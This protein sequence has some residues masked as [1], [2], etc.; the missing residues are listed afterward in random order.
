MEVGN[1][2]QEKKVCII[3]PVYN[4][5]K[6][7]GYCLNSVLSQT[8]GNWTAILVD[9]GSTDSSAG[10]CRRYEK[11]DDRFHYVRKANGGVSSARNRG[12]E[13]A[14]GDYLAFL[15]SDD[16][17]AQDMLEKLVAAA[18]DYDSNLVV[19]NAMILDFNDPAGDRVVL[20]TY[21]P[22][23]GPRVLSRDVFRETQM[24]TIWQTCM[25]EGPL[26]KLYDL[27]L[28][29]QLGVTF[30][31]E[32][33][34]GEDFVTNLQYYSACGTVVFLEDCGYYYHQSAGSGSLSEKYRPDLFE[35]KVY[36]MERLEAHLGG[37]E[38]LSESERDAYFT[39]VAAN[40][41][42]CVEK[43]VL[44]SGLEKAALQ[45]KLRQMLEHP[46]FVESLERAVFVP[47]R[48]SGCLGMIRKGN[49]KKLSRYISK[50][51]GQKMA[52]GQTGEAEDQQQA[53]DDEGTASLANR[54]IGS[55]L[56]VLIL[57]CGDSRPGR[58]LARL[59]DML[60][61]FGIRG[62]VEKYILYNNYISEQQ[63]RDYLAA[64]DREL[65]Q[66]IEKRNRSRTA[67]AEELPDTGNQEKEGN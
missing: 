32:L 30:P 64:L 58:E 55:F 50:N 3:I 39:Y 62:I 59:E 60:G 7:L 27:Q 57:I 15:D 11:L 66:Y 40:F 56:H 19:M 26:S 16:C 14:E 42:A 13:L 17:W 21:W 63:R 8:Y 1:V 4:A 47:E 43:T 61:Y 49:L 12:I 35:I 37:R 65:D 31:E 48:F 18:L 6:Y 23:A 53:C 38:N 67:G 52:A 25:M 5:E 54:V 2:R 29:K 10:I 20:N 9:D 51:A 45:E 28:W 34:Y 44:S 22:E 24:H 41:L 36:L 33:S 46:L